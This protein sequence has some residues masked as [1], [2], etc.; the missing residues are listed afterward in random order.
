M[1]HAPVIAIIAVI[2]YIWAS[3]GFFSAFLHM[4]CVIVCGTLA[5]ALWEPAAHFIMSLD[6]SRTGWLTEYAWTMGLLLPF[7]LLLGA[8][9]LAVDKLIPWNVDLDGASNLIGGGVCGLVSGV[10][11]A[12]IVLLGGQYLRLGTEIMGWNAVAYESNGSL[13]HKSKVIPPADR[14]TAWFFSRL[15]DTT[16]RPMSGDSLAKWKPDMADA[17]HLLRVTFPPPDGGG[18]QT[19]KPD[20]AEILGRYV[21]EPGSPKDLTTDSFDEV[22]NQTYNYVDGSSLSAGQS[23][24]EG[25][26]VRFKAGAKEKTGRIVVG[27]GHVRLIV[28]NREDTE[29]MAIAP[30]AVISQAAGDSPRLGRWRFD[31]P[32]AFIASVGGRD[33]AP[34]AFEFP[35]PKGSKPLGLEVKGIRFDVRNQKPFATFT[36]M[37]T[38]DAAILAGTITPTRAAEPLDE[39]TAVVYPIVPNDIGAFIRMNDGLFDG[40]MIQKDNRKEIE[41]LEEGQRNWII[42]GFAKFNNNEIQRGAGID[43]RLQVRRFQATEDTVILQVVV[44][45][46]NTAFG[47]L[48]NAAANM[49]QSKAPTVYDHNGT[50]YSPLGF[51]YK[52]SG[53]TWIRFTPQTPILAVTD[54]PPLTRSRPEQRLILVYRVSKNVRIEKFAVGP[55]VLAA[56]RPPLDTATTR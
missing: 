2:A 41:I 45:I 7:C 36:S 4:L 49:E 1:I 21:F 51:M 23:Y 11:T 50:P 32:N 12:G 8:I 29:S 6:D 14:M 25:F 5:F 48:S 42:G 9:R 44:D 19:I 39:S 15:S 20:A 26:V 18:R 37:A 38:R 34:M 56:F 52:D 31:A 10:L 35:V 55:K 27:S 16:F 17:G 40:L 47:F 46:T 43:Q 53:E 22:R 28:R 24:I 33:D 3:R 54:L 30:M 13:V